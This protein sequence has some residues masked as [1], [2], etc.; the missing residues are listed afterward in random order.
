[1][2]QLE[3]AHPFSRCSFSH[4]NLLS[5]R[6]KTIEVRVTVRNIADVLMSR[7]KHTIPHAQSSPCV[8]LSIGARARQVQGG[9]GRGGGKDRKQEDRERH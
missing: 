3:I 7:S 5:Q 9:A 4:K 1:M 8:N 2:V 6:K